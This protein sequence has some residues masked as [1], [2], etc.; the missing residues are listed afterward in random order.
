MQS[1]TVLGVRKAVYTIPTKG[2]VPCPILCSVEIGNKERLRQSM[3]CMNAKPVQVT[4]V[5]KNLR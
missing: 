3:S 5:Y 1:Q 4:T 2:Y